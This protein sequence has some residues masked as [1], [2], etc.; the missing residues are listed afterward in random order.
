MNDTTVS[1]AIERK[2]WLNARARA[3]AQ[4]ADVASLIRPI[5]D[6]LNARLDLLAFEPE[7]ILLIGAW[8][9]GLALKLLARYPKS[10]LWLVEMVDGFIE[11]AQKNLKNNNKIKYLKSEDLPLPCADAAVDLLLSAVSLP[12]YWP[13]NAF[14]AECR[15][16]LRPKGYLSLATIGER[17][18]AA[19]RAASD[20]LGIGSVVHEFIDI[21]SLGMALVTA[22]FAD[23]VV[24]REWV[25]ASYS[26]FNALHR[27]LK[28]LGAINCRADRSKGLGPK[29]RLRRW[30]ECLFGPQAR[31]S[32]TAEVLY[33]QGFAPTGLPPKRVSRTEQV[34]PFPRRQA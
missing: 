20:E 11:R 23:P 14:L 18:L 26:Q 24:D 29:T 1:A 3:V 2:R 19:L 17:S 27:D 30:Q 21:E 16:V 28:N 25:S 9:E 5:G 6:E 15:R 32:I 34:L 7:R 31:V 10:E 8:D 12:P 13:W 4:F 22:G 33:A